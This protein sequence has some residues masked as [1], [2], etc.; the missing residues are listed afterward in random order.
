MNLTFSCLKNNSVNVNS[1]S[2]ESNLIEKENYENEQKC[3]PNH[4]GSIDAPPSMGSPPPSPEAI[5]YFTV[6][7]FPA[8]MKFKLKVGNKIL[9]K[10]WDDWQTKHQHVIFKRKIAEWRGIAESDIKIVP[11]WTKKGNMHY[12]IV[13]SSKLTIK[14]I[15]IQFTDAYSVNH[16]IRKYFCKTTRITDEDGLKTYLRKETGKQDQYTGIEW[17]IQNV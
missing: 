4:L 2:C 12:N 15:D 9:S 11:E 5:R 17:N 8:N 3:D 13:Y 6:L 16:N 7:N 14:D 1:P 10:K